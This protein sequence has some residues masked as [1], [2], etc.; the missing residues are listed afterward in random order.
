MPLRDYECGMCRRVYQDVLEKR[1]QHMEH[2]EDCGGLVRLLISKASFE[3]VGSG[4]ARD[5]YGL[6]NDT[7]KTKKD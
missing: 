2:C 3:L 7:G 5:N 4:W 1:E 6:V